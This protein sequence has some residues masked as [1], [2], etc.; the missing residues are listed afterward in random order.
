M[1]LSGTPE[2]YATHA[3]VL[4]Q[5]VKMTSGPILECG[6]GMGSTPLLHALSDGK[7]RVVTLDSEDSWCRKFAHL[8]TP[9]HMIARVDDWNQFPWEATRWSVALI[10]QHPV[11]A[12]LVAISALMDNCD[13]IVVHDTEEP[14][15]FYEPLLR[16]FKHRY[17][18]KRDDPWATVV[19]NTMEFRPCD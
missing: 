1:K 12:R 11:S 4:G 10:D 3:R 17:D 6:A 7:R 18:D 14:R 13:L 15:Y 5:C 16:Q 9:W 8:A 19:S 2:G